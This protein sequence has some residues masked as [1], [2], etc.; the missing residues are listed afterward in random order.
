MT[1]TPSATLL[2]RLS[3][4]W[5]VP[6]R[7]MIEPPTSLQSDRIKRALSAGKGPSPYGRLSRARGCLFRQLKR[8]IKRVQDR[9]RLLKRRSELGIPIGGRLSPS[10]E[11]QKSGELA[12][13][14]SQTYVRFALAGA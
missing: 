5:S 8:R 11:A 12:G 10:R 3:W 13:Y 6:R 2:K 9:D 1:F 14:G 7:G 4:A